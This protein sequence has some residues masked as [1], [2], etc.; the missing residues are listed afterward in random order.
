MKTRTIV[1]ILI[2][3]LAVLII[4]GSCAT[5][6]KAS[7]TERNLFKEL[8]GTWVNTEYTGKWLGYEQKLIVYPDGK[9]EYYLL[10]TDTNPLRQGYLLTITEVWTDSEGIIWYK[11]TLEEAGGPY[12]ELGKISESGN[13]WETIGDAINNPTEWDTS[14]T[15]YEYYEI[16]YR[17]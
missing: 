1:S 14:K 16:R 4:V 17:Q 2:L 10:T 15:R 6:K 9:F 8:S 11:A 13:T 3:V 5:G 7:V 12:Y